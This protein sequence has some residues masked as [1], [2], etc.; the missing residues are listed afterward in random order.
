MA[1]GLAGDLCEAALKMRLVGKAAGQRDIAQR[2]GGV[3]HHAHGLFDPV[4]Q[5][6]LHR[7]LAHGFA[8]HAARRCKHHARA[9]IVIFQRIAQDHARISQIGI[10]ELRQID[11]LLPIEDQTQLAPRKRFSPRG[12]E[13]H[14]DHVRAAKPAPARAPSSGG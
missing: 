1:R 4:G 5:H 6:I 8:K 3:F 13:R 9:Q 14:D 12:I 7:R 11:Q 10:A 2:A